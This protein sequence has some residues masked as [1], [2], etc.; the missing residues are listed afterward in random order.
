MS[1]INTEQ[2]SAKISLDNTNSTIYNESIKIQ[3]E[4]FDEKEIVCIAVR[5]GHGVG[6]FIVERVPQA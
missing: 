4:F 3:E 1:K 2:I 5:G 6:G